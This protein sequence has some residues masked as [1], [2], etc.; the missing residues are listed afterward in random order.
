MKIEPGPFDSFDS[1]LEQEIPDQAKKK[2]AHPLYDG[3]DPSCPELTPFHAMKGE[4]SWNQ[5]RRGRSVTTRWLLN[6]Q[7]SIK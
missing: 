5:R 4:V 3:H 7:L 1:K 6:C 2:K